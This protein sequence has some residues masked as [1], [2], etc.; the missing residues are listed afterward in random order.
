M[1]QATSLECQVAQVRR[2]IKRKYDQLRRSREDAEEEQK[3]KYR[4]I[5]EP[6]YELIKKKKK[7]KI[8]DETSPP[9]AR[10]FPEIKWPNILN[11]FPFATD[12]DDDDDDGEISPHG[13]SKIKITKRKRNRQVQAPYPTNNVTFGSL[14]TRI[15]DLAPSSSRAT[16]PAAVVVEQ[17]EEE[18]AVG[19]VKV[20]EEQDNELAK[21]YI[22][23]TIGN[24]PACDTQY[25]VRYTDGLGLCIGDSIL[26]IEND[27]IQIGDEFRVN[28]TQ[29]LL[30][31]LF[32]R[33]PNL[34]LVSEH[35]K[36][37]YR[38]IVKSTNLHRKKYSAG[39]G[40]N[41]NL[42]NPKWTVIKQILDTKKP[43]PP[44][45]LRPP[46]GGSSKSNESL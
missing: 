20:E 45:V 40:L 24:D 9:P 7:K 25:G 30:E 3:I 13:T 15:E 6:L 22:S 44:K 11:F 37:M 19:G 36:S 32:L 4:P 5:R 31:L 17:E 27:V 12:D 18:G 39:E 1:E 43:P 10:A 33:K 26:S 42:R 16:S 38:K 46:S 35:D 28:A 8:A 41:M 14:S 29:G 2:D 23:K 21:D 34:N